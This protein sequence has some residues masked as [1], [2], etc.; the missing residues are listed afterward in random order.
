MDGYGPPI[1]NLHFD[2]HATD[3]AMR[4]HAFGRGSALY[5]PVGAKCTIH[6]PPSPSIRNLGPN[7]TSAKAIDGVVNKHGQPHDT[8][9]LFISDGSQFTTGASE[10]PPLTIVALAFRQAEFSHGGL[11]CWLD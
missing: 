4:E 3:V 9:N 8:T 10:N 6:R 2:D 7:R 5:D 11:L 1:P